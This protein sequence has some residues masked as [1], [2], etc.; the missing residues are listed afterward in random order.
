MRIEH[1]RTADIPAWLK[2]AS[3]VEHLFGPMVS[4]PGFHSALEKNIERGTALCIREDEGSPGAPLMGGI[5]LGYRPLKIEIDWLAVA[6]R[7]RRY[8]VGRALMNHVLELA[9]PPVEMVLL[10]FGEHEPGGAAA[11]HFYESFGFQ[12]SEVGP[13]NSAG[14]QTQVYRRVVGRTPTVRAVIQ[15][16]DRYLLVQHNNKVPEHIGKWG[17]PGG[18]IDP[19]DPNRPATLRRELREELQI[20]VEVLRFL[21]TYAYRERLHHVF[22]VHPYSTDLT[23]D[24]HEILDHAWLTADEVAT[25]HA[26]NRL[27]TG[28]ELDAITKSKQHLA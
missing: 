12:P 1:A 6:E 26:E 14:K 22:H 5:L 25:W 18:R 24:R 3:E 15:H 28:F 20:E 11:R 9:Q 7:W 23:I 21:N 16:A 8:G 13:T 19:T 4:D 17:I 2:L 10:T 27:H